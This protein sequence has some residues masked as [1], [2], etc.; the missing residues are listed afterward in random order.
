MIP[1]KASPAGRDFRGLRLRLVAATALV[2]LCGPAFAQRTPPEPAARPL[3]VQIVSSGGEP[4]LRVD[5]VPFFVHAAQFD[6]F[7]IPPGLWFR[8]LARYHELGINTIDLRIPWNWHELSD[9]QF[10]FNGHTDLRRDL[11]GLVQQIAQMGFKL[12][13]RPGPLT[14]DHWRNDGIP[15]WLLAYSDYKMS[16]ANI[17]QGI[18]PPLARLAARDANAAARGWLANPTHMTY[19]RRWMTAVARV[20]APY[21]AKNLISVIEP[22]GRDGETQEKKIPGPLLFVALDDAE[23]IQPGADTSELKRYLAELR[24]ALAAGGLD[25]PIFLS[26]PNAGIQGLSPI[27][28]NASADGASQISLAGQWYFNPPKQAMSA[29]P[30]SASAA[31]SSQM[32]LLKT[33]DALSLS[34]L[35]RTLG[36][37]PNFPPFLSGFAETTFT[38]AGDIRAAQPPPEDLFLASRLLIGSGIRG[39]VYSPLQDTLTPAGWGT[40]SVAPYFRWDAPL[41]IAGNKGPRARGVTRN[42]QFIS[43]WGAMLAGSHAHADFGIMDLRVSA[44]KTDAA[45]NSRYAGEMEQ[46]FRAASLAGYVPELVNPAAQSAARLLRDHVI[47]LPVPPGRGSDFRLSEKAQAAL[48]EFVRQ[49]GALVYFPVRPQGALLEPLWHGAASSA[50]PGQNVNGWAFERG[51]VI[52]ASSDFFSWSPPGENLNNTLAQPKSK[53]AESFAALLERS[54]ARRGLRRMGTGESD[55]SLIAGEIVS[56]SAPGSPGRA[57]KCAEGQLCAAALISVTNLNP[58]QPVHESF[59]WSDPRTAASVRP[60]PKI[61]F[62]VSV[63]ARE[64]LLLPVHAPLCSAAKPGER[65]SDEV[66]VAG[67]ELLSAQRNKKTLELTFY[68]PSRAVVR[69]HLERAPSKVMLDENIRLDSDWNQET[70]DLEVHIMRGAVPDFLRVLRVYLRYTPHVSET[71]DRENYRLGGSEYEVFN[72]IR[73][74]LGAGVT[75]PTSPP[76]IAADADS[77]GYLVMSSQNYS[78]TLR[79]SNF[80]LDGAFHGSGNARMYGVDTEFTRIRFQPVHNPAPTPGAETHAAPPD[81]LLRGNLTIRSGRRQATGDVLFLAPNKD[82]NAHYQYDFDQDGA[83][84]WALE[85]SRLRLIV[86]PASSGQALALVDKSTNEDLITLGGALHDFL[87]PAGTAPRDVWRLGDF[88]FNR[89]YRAKWIEEKPD[90][91]LQLTYSE[92]DRSAAG[93]HVEKTVRLAEQGTVEADY[94]FSVAAPRAAKPAKSGRTG[95]SF[96]S[97]LSVPV[98]DPEEGNTRFCWSTGSSTIATGEPSAARAASKPHCENFVSSGA[99]ITLPEGVARLE[100]LYP[101]R[102]PLAVEWTAG[103]TVIVPRAFSA[104]VYFTVPVPALPEA[105]GGFTL[106]YTV[107]KGP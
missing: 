73:F 8:S 26:V 79:F 31:P 65:C 1:V 37:Q 5:G 16:A 6:Y 46:M 95:M 99:P 69:L 101:G 82:G 38:P 47:V 15:A 30:V 21:S 58:D 84:E 35:A 75:I 50:V 76:L 34:F 85:N 94:R 96:I 68:T 13:V 42:G 106:R 41:D 89:A 48:V 92:H 63:P 87:V 14:G 10:D 51:R 103:R 88:S 54:G 64:S 45:A 77:G 32:P 59:E 7:R 19:A 107:G 36:T 74:P 60:E 105:S 66:V 81:G 39:L 86:S 71:P 62:D 24:G 57:Q 61:A 17:Q 70:G 72:G 53:A 9:A 80:T 97:M 4:E 56:N 91:G 12:I 25:G 40:Q 100:I 93:V 11:R 52:A 20:L 23:G 44:E 43:E 98:S 102:S 28:G 83:N 104:Q 22:V 3:G 33:A 55:P 90:A 67:A 29:R 18:A 27:F 49:G 2:F 78:H